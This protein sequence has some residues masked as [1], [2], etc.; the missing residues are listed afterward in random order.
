MLSVI[1]CFKSNLAKINFNICLNESQVQEQNFGQNVQK[2]GIETMDQLNVV[3]WCMK[4]KEHQF[5][6]Q[7]QNYDKCK[8][9]ILC[10]GGYQS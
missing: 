5:K 9:N 7:F 2:K 6:V 10:L 8:L 4:Y 1:G 3:K